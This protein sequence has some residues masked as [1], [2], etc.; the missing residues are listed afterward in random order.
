MPGASP[1]TRVADLCHLPEPG[2]TRGRHVEML[3]TGLGEQL[4]YL[5]G[6]TKTCKGPLSLVAYLHGAGLTR[7]LGADRVLRQAVPGLGSHERQ[8]I[9]GAL[10]LL[11]ARGGN[12]QG[13]IKR[14]AR[15]TR[16]AD[17]VAVR[18]AAIVA[19]A[20]G[21][22]HSRSQD[23]GLVGVDDDGEAVE[24]LV[25]GGP[26]LPDAKTALRE[27]DLWNAT[28]LRPIRAVAVY[29]EG[30]PVLA[31]M[32]PCETVAVAARRVFQR[33][34]EQFLSRAY[35]LAY[36]R[37]RE[38]VHEMRV[39]LR[40]LRAALRVL[41]DGVHE[42]TLTKFRAELKWLAD[43]LG[44]VR[45]L[46]VLLAFLASYAA[47][48][49]EGH[50]PFLDGLVRAQ[51]RRRRQCYRGLVDAVESPRFRRFRDTHYS[52]LV[53][54]GQATP[55]LLPQGELGSREVRALAP[56]VLR[57]RLK[58]ATRYGRQLGG[59]TAAE[60]HR[61]RIEC[62]RL[63]YT[64]EFFLEIYPGRLREIAGPMRRMQDTLGAV[65]DADVYTQRIAEYC[66]RRG[67]DTSAAAEALLS[68]L[69]SWRQDNLGEAAK[70]WKAFTKPKA[71][72]KL[73]DLIRSPKKR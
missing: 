55:S 70:L 64:T 44:P 21:L 42:E 38:Y 62:K 63:R 50:R 28:M 49:P 69:S 48:A 57:K 58:K 41:G 53:N 16:A 2:R 59:L 35:G 30:R 52:M 45:D 29:E 25:S 51:R 46:D 9:V 39:A 11:A 65:H 37:D 20:D 7:P 14:S 68:H 15:D 4:G 47:Q 6:L 27:A 3:A 26:A 60:Q 1:L 32:Q 73:L 54:G 36:D 66:R 5:H 17:G 71:L 22:D 12:R 8:A 13:T 56:R 23:T 19:I 24:I 43:N 33:Q 67:R 40:R 34:F 18:L 61:L 10:Q 72:R 31:L